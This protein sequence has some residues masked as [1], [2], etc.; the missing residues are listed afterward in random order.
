[1]GL[2]SINNN[3]IQ[4]CLINIGGYMFLGRTWVVRS[5][6]AGQ[7]AYVSWQECCVRYRHILNEC[8][9]RYR[10]TRVL[11]TAVLR[12]HFT[13][14]ASL[15]LLLGPGCILCLLCYTITPPSGRKQ[16]TTNLQ[17]RGKFV[18]QVCVHG[19]IYDFGSPTVNAV[20]L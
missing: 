13:P 16:V 3:Q 10:Y 7:S 19:P 8:C 5:P 4:I 20:L 6:G 14:P 9:V 17:G 2:N 18:V 12:H 1:M 15:P 11:N